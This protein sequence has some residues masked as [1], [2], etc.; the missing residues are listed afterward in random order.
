MSL[1]LKIEAQRCF[2]ETRAATCSPSDRCLSQVSHLPVSLSLSVPAASLAP[3]ELGPTLG[4][5]KSSSL[6]S[7]QTAI[8][9]VN[10]NQD[11][12]PFHRPRQHMVRGR[13][14][15]ESFRAA[16]DKS[17][18]GPPEGDDGKGGAWSQQR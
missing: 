15:N 6:E 1:I 8:S 18:D 17:Y 14:C 16:I 4:L 9:E 5:K 7:L 13:G 3:V 2:S 12:L 10:R 11:F